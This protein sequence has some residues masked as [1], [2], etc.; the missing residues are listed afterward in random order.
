MLFCKTELTGWKY[1]INYI[2]HPSGSQNG[3]K[4]SVQ[5][6]DSVF[7]CMWRNLMRHEPN[8]TDYIG[9]LIILSLTFESFLYR[10]F[11]PKTDKFCLRKC[12]NPWSYIPT[13]FL[14]P[15]FLAKCLNYWSWRWLI[16]VYYMQ[17]DLCIKNNE[18]FCICE[19]F[20][21]ILLLQ[22]LILSYNWNAWFI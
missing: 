22:V 15:V 16:N 3:A 7:C 6:F 20:S 2:N 17:S 19:K 21:F 1:L 10:L 8:W 9:K 4:I 18:T 5:T 14:G 12:N 13:A 11:L